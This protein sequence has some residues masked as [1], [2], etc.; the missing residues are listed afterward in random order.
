[1][2][3]SA[4]IQHL[5]LGGSGSVIFG[6]GALRFGSEPVAFCK[7]SRKK[8]DQGSLRNMHM[9]T[10]LLHKGIFAGPLYEQTSTIEML[11]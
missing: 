6:L 10:T 3:F 5:F 7:R 2:R 11:F 9:E 1:M 8:K 4:R